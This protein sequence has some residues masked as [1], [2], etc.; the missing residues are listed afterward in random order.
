MMPVQVPS[1]SFLPKVVQMLQDGF[2]NAS[3]EGKMHHCPVHRQTQVP[4]LHRPEPIN[5]TAYKFQFVP[6]VKCMDCPNEI[7]LVTPFYTIG[8]IEDHLNSPNH[9]HRVRLRWIAESKTARDALLVTTAPPVIV[10]ALAKLANGDLSL[11]GLDELYSAKSGQ[12]LLVLAVKNAAIHVLRH[13]LDEGLKVAGTDSVGRTALHWAYGAG[14]SDMAELL[15]RYGARVSTLDKWLG[16][17]LELAVQSGGLNTGVALIEFEASVRREASPE[18]SETP[19]ALACRYGHLAIIERMI[20]SGEN[21]NEGRINLPLH[22]A[23]RKASWRV[24]QILLAAGANPQL[25]PLVDRLTLMGRG[26]DDGVTYP[27]AKEKVA[28]LK[29]HGLRFKPTRMVSYCSRY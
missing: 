25:I 23:V 28:L 26:A 3:I 6:T 10:T 7:F 9:A 19:L 2:P 22:V 15:V 27:D 21:V 16:T 17:P 29:Q 20:E 1:P 8:P 11:P 12:P 18:A 5:L 4:M 13:L 14:R 24:V